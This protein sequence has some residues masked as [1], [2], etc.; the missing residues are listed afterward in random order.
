M[1]LDS[2]A[3]LVN[4]QDDP[5]LFLKNYPP[6]VIFDEVQKAPQLFAEIKEYPLNASQLENLLRGGFPA[7]ALREI[8]PELD[9]VAQRFAD[10][11]ATYLTRDLRDP[12]QI[13]NLGRFEKWLRCLATV[14]ARIRNCLASVGVSWIGLVLNATLTPYSSYQLLVQRTSSESSWD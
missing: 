2:V 12:A 8:T 1:L 10:Y 4:A 14:S 9:D 6:P 13:Q 11:T 7:M 3:V 5:A